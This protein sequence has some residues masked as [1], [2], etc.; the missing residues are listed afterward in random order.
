MARVP[1]HSSHICQKF[2]TAMDLL[3]KRWTG[4]LVNALQEGPL[5][6]NQIAERMEVI[7]DRMLS[8]RLKELEEA[9]VL[10]RRVL[11]EPVIRVEYALTRKGRSLG[12]VLASISRWADDWVELPAEQR[13]ASR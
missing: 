1:R 5:R 2:Q 3:G 7:G 6:F 4:L 8:E 10:E 9:G 12:R 11:S 13:K